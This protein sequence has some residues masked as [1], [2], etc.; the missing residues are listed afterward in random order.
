MLKLG[1]DIQG[2]KGCNV[3][4]TITRPEDVTHQ[5]HVRISSAAPKEDD[6]L[7][8]HRG[9][10]IHFNRANGRMRIPQRV[11]VNW[12]SLGGQSVATARAYANMILVAC[13]LA[14]LIEAE[15]E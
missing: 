1:E 14:E 10:S 8:Y 7:G 3:E 6:G 4:W 15:Y 9:V 5:G 2:Y 12:A 11:E 13:E